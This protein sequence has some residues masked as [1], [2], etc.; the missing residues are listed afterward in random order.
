[1]EKYDV[2][3][4][5]DGTTCWHAADSELYHHKQYHR[6]DGPAFTTAEGYESWFLD[7]KRH[8]ED[9][10]AVIH[11]DGTT[12]WY[13]CGERH[14][15]DGPAIDDA[16]GAE[17]WFWHGMLHRIDGPAQIDEDGNQFWFLNGVWMKRAEYT[18]RVRQLAA[19]TLFVTA[20]NKLTWIT[21]SSQD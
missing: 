12:E 16:S 1:M 9:G 8:R 4:H 5:Q 11:P 20:D 13:Y 21:Q 6:I 15:V 10:P 18:E 3:V 2:E 14:R 17:S 7:G 19:G